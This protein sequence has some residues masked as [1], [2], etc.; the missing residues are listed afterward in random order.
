LHQLGATG[1]NVDSAAGIYHEHLIHDCIG[2]FMNSTKGHYPSRIN[3]SIDALVTYFTE[4]SGKIVAITN[5]NVC[6]FQAIE[7]RIKAFEI[8][9]QQAHLGASCSKLTNTLCAQGPRCSN[10]NDVFIGQ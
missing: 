4:R 8:P 9:S 1:H 6:A 2:Y 10:D 3:D 7:L 5:I